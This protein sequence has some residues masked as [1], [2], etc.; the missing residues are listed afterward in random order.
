MSRAD[1][2]KTVWHDEFPRLFTKLKSI[3]RLSK[4]LLAKADVQLL[5]SCLLQLLDVLRPRCEKQPRV[6]LVLLR[7][8]VPQKAKFEVLELVQVVEQVDEPLD[9]LPNQ[10]TKLL[11]AVRPL[12][13]YESKWVPFAPLQFTRCALVTAL[14]PVLWPEQKL[15]VRVSYTN[16]VLKVRRCR[17]SPRYGNRIA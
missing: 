8:K 3:T 10:K 6:K 9:K 12:K 16:T 5:H 1:L 11:L 7:C 15:F 14:R 2:L 4:L 13:P 17:V